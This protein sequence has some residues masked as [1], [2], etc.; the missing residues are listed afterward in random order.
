MNSKN[1]KQNTNFQIVYFLVGSCHTPD[2]AYALLQDLREARQMAVDNYAVQ[3]L[4]NQAKELEA[5][6]LLES[7]YEVDKLNGQAELLELSNNKK[8]GKVLYDAAIDELAFIDKCIDAVQPLRVYKELS[9]SE[10]S[11][12][13]QYEE[14]KL[15]LIHRA[16]N[17]MITS[18][19]VPTDHFATMRMHPAFQDEILPRINEMTAMMQSRDGLM[20]LQKQLEGYKFKEIIKLLK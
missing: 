8:I 2:G 5:R 4:K 13:A 17:A 19:G 3:E 18:G 16:E 9:D 11:E 10:A 20:K 6:E 14:W 7:T 1:H 15:E 12:L